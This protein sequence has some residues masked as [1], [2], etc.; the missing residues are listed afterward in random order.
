MHQALVGSAGLYGLASLRRWPLLGGEELPARLKL[1]PDLLAVPDRSASAP[2]DPVAIER[3]RSYDLAALSESL[4]KAFDALGGLPALVRGKAV[5]VKLNITGDGRQKMAGLPAERTFQ[6]HPAMGE[7]L[8]GLLAK[9]GAKRI[10]LAE[11]YYRPKPPE[12]ILKAH[13]WDPKRLLSAGEHKVEFADTRNRGPFKD[14]ATLKVPYGGYV[15]PAYLL[16]RHYADTD[17]FISLAKLKNH[18]TAGIT[19]AVKNLFGIAPTALYGNDSP[20]ENTTEN[21]GDT[22]HSGTRP[23]PG[24]VPKDRYPMP[25]ELL[26]DA[27]QAGP[28]RVPR[29]T[30]DLLALRPLDLAIVDGIEAVSGGEGPWCPPPHKHTRPGVIVAGRN[31]VAVDAVCAGIMG[32]DPQS[33]YGE[34]PF[35]GENHLNLLARAGVGSNDLARLEIRGVA[36]KEALYEYHPNPA[37]PGWVKRKLVNG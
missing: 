9:A 26:K 30:A 15:Y 1:P 19:G 6:T 31:A 11:S 13:G 36:L 3:C 14:Y 8:A 17:V 18:V 27:A 22:L 28:Y 37:K 12:E 2:A 35:P 24:G 20:N 34:F 16:N 10:V 33:G 4:Q 21:R 29:V 32:Y 23:V 25:E 7:A 5:T